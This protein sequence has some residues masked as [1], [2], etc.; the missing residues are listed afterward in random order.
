MNSIENM[1]KIVARG[2]ADA[3][4]DLT[5]VEYGAQGV[6]GTGE[7]AWIDPS[8]GVEYT[9]A[10]NSDGIEATLR[11][12]V[13]V[14]HGS[15]VDYS[16]PEAIAVWLSEQRFADAVAAIQREDAD[17]VRPLFMRAELEDEMPTGQIDDEYEA[18]VTIVP[19]RITSVRLGAV[20]NRSRQPGALPITETTANIGG[21]DK[22]LYP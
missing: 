10:P 4:P 7:Q 8:V 5:F 16:T 18:M 11:F 6:A 17:F 9:L 12:A 13:S 20:N 3:F 19:F 1:R 21:E 2:L 14:M 15:G 22:R